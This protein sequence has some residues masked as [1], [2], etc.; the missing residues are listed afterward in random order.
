MAETTKVDFV[1]TL[2]EVYQSL[3]EREDAEWEAGWVHD[4]GKHIHR[5]ENENAV[6][7][8]SLKEVTEK[9]VV[10]DPGV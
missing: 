7:R 3:V 2:G 9:F 8:Q 10:A 5:L 4:A 1:A 6:L